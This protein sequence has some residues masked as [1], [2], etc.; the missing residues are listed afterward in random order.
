MSSVVETD[1]TE[2][3]VRN[4]E[5]M[6]LVGTAYGDS[7]HPPVLFLHGGGQTRHSWGGTAETLARQGYYCITIDHRG[8]GH[9]DWAPDGSYEYID[10]AR[11]LHDWAATLSTPP[12]I[13]GASLGGNTG[14]MALGAEPRLN[15]R[16]FIMVDITPKVEPKGVKRI[17]DFMS[18][19]AK[20]GF[21]SLEDAAA[22]VQ[23][24]T[25]E[26]KRKVDLNSIRKNLRQRENGRWYWHWDP[27]FLNKRG[28]DLS[29]KIES[30]LTD[31]VRNIEC[32]VLLVR[33]RY[34]DVVSEESVAAF[35]EL[36]PDSSFV[37]VSGA[38]H[39]VAGD[40]NDVFTEA[41]VE[42]LD[43]VEGRQ[44]SLSA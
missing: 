32:P 14:M 42:F 18:A 6:N 3:S 44:N 35:K 36:L 17:L 38:G 25:P 27:A 13:V 26:R 21:A 9:S 33:G 34:S 24:Y 28:D 11:D 22:A 5:G 4:R 8:H 15:A 41:V 7:A 20:T 2:V 23:A 37:D 29:R 12:V 43:Q 19:D 10:H 30:T 40:R 39:M 31:A 16:A 1:G